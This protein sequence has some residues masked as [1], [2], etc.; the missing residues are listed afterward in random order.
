MAEKAQ[1]YLEKSF[2]EILDLQKK[3]I[4]TP[5]EIN[6][7][8]K[9]RSEF[10]HALSRR[11][12]KKSDFLKY[13]EY[14]MNLEALRKKR[15]K[16]LN[17][18]GKPTISDWGGVRRIFLIF[19]RATKKFHGDID[20]WFQY[21]H[22][23]QHEK[24]TKI[25]GRV[26][27]SALQF[28]PTK[29]K[30]WIFAG[31]HELNWNNNMS[32]ARATMQRGLRLNMHSP[33]LWTEY[34]RMELL[35][36]IKLSTRHKIL[37][38]YGTE[39]N[40]SDHESIQDE[41]VQGKD[42]EEVAQEKNVVK[43]INDDCIILSET[44]FEK[45]EKTHSIVPT[46]TDPKQSSGSVPNLRDNPVMNGE[47]ISIIIKTSIQHIQNNIEL[48]ESFYNMIESFDN[49][50]CKYRLLDEI[51]SLIREVATIDLA[52][53]ALL[54]L[55]LHK[56]LKNV[57]NTSFPDALKSS[58]LGFETLTT[59]TNCSIMSYE[60]FCLLLNSFLDK[61]GLDHNLCIIIS[62]FLHTT[63]KKLETLG[64]LSPKL[65]KL[66]KRFTSIPETNMNSDPDTGSRAPI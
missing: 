26:I 45:Y 56:F 54:T 36:I 51:V 11:I 27:A 12:V 22:Y 7:I 49:L 28:H 30:L 2:P 44:A 63:L 3:K 23:A 25:I 40:K 20:L 65:K 37:G 61:E 19:E 35:Y 43:T 41:I 31:Y 58:L 46:N 8:L 64:P 6:S 33:E 50:E 10:E 34:C 16:R 39:D 4:F 18:K 9:K 5:V 17:I 66:Q 38:I 29:P 21:I 32:A 42:I 62:C 48:L 14:E 52:E 1:Y 47:I 60:K 57:S 15:A 13:I 53:V 55:P 24:S 59:Q